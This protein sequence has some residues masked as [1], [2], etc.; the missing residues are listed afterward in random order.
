MASFSD[1]M[2]DK[3]H[4][5]I[6]PEHRQST[7][8]SELE[9]LRVRIS[10]I[11]DEAQRGSCMA[12]LANYEEHTALAEQKYLWEEA[13]YVAEQ[14][15]P[16]PDLKLSMHPDQRSYEQRV[17]AAEQDFAQSERGLSLR[18][19]QNARTDQLWD[20]LKAFV[21]AYASAPEKV[22]TQQ[23]RDADRDQRQARSDFTRSI[24]R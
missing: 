20:N 7:Q 8:I 3:K 21:D 23:N 16:E 4:G 19:E 24:R 15:K 11:G 9:A 6:V 1:E 5:S 2:S 17:D 13:R 10:G 14:V 22:P 12:R 18:Q